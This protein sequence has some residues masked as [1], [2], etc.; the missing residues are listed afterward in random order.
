[1]DSGERLT[2]READFDDVTPVSTP[3][4]SEAERRIADWW[5]SSPGEPGPPATASNLDEAGELV[6]WAD[7]DAESVPASERLVESE[8]PPTLESWTRQIPPPLPE[9]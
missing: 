3:T 5:D 7:D 4:L 8:C 1:M 9:H 6:F 2:R